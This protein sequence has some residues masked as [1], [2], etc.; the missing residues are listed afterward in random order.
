MQYENSYIS[1][2][3][4]LAHATRRYNVEIGSLHTEANFKRT[5]EKIDNLFK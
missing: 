3:V 4:T 5:E 2:V 1:A